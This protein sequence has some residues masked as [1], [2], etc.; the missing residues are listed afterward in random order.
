VHFQWTEKSYV[1]YHYRV[2]HCTWSKWTVNRTWICIV[3]RREHACNAL[4]I[5][6]LRRW[7][8]LHYLSARH[9]LTPRDH[10]YGLLHRVVCMRT[11]FQLS[12]VLIAPTHRGITRLSRS[13]VAGSARRRFTRRKTATHPST[14]RARRS[15]TSL[16]DANVLPLS[17]IVNKLNST[18]N[19]SWVFCCAFG[20]LTE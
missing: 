9:Q 5:H 20:F 2:T 4:L 11:P 12:L 14:N 8:E 19:R 13:G 18:G 1:D 17:Q 3:H 10:G 15:G 16:M 6:A 7:P